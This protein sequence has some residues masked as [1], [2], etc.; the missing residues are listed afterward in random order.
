MR[1]TLQPAFL[2]GGALSC[3]TYIEITG[4]VNACSTY[5]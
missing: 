1:K 5:N 3:F 4:V 2:F